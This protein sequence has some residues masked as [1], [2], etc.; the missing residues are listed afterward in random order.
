MHE[1]DPV[2]SLLKRQCFWYSGSIYHIV[3]EYYDCESSTSFDI[4]E[5]L[6]DIRIP[7]NDYLPDLAGRWMGLKVGGLSSTV[8]EIIGPKFTESLERERAEVSF[9]LT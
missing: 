6:D 2:Y 4:N 5:E 1:H 7:L 3:S 8:L 9:I